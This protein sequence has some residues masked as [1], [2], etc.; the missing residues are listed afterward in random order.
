MT[1]VMG[2]GKIDLLGV[3][4]NKNDKESKKLLRLKMVDLGYAYHKARK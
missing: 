1:V 3:A 4:A 2:K